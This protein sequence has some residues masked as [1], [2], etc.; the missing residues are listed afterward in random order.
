[1]AKKKR[2]EQSM[3]NDIMDAISEIAH[4]HNVSFNTAAM[5]TFMVV[6][7]NIEEALKGEDQWVD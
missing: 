2:E 6:R 5:E 7:Y 4:K 1:M 3:V